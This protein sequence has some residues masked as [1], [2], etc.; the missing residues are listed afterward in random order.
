MAAA[1]GQGI[2]HRDLKPDNIFLVSDPEN[3]GRERVK[4]LDFGIAKLVLPS[5]TASQGARDVRTST[6]MLLGTP[7]FM[8]PEQCRGAGQIDHRADIYSVGCILYMMLTGRPPFDHEGVGE[9]L[10]AHLH[11]QVVPPRTLEPSVP[12]ALEAIT[13][14]ALDKRPEAR[15]QSMARAGRRSCSGSWRRRS[16]SPCRRPRP[17]AGGA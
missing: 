1:H 6:G 5:P 10:A 3:P 11:E 14:R 4:I 16:R 13:L 2:V 7:L 8:A 15:F 17:L 12:A 9:V